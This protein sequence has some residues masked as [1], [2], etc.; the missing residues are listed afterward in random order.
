MYKEGTDTLRG[1][2]SLQLASALISRGAEISAF[3]PYVKTLNENGIRLCLVP[4]ENSRD[5]DAIIFLRD[6]KFDISTM[7]KIKS[8]MKGNLL[9]DVQNSF[10]PEQMQEIGYVYIGTGR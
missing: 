8:L 9:V 2:L 6:L 7:N 3:D 4:E 5:S 1:S 10:K